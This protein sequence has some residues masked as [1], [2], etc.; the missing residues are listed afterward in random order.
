MLPQK[1]LIQ[2]TTTGFKPFLNRLIIIMYFTAEKLVQFH[3]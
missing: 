3:Q 2:I 1:S